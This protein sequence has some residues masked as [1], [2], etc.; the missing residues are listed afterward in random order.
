MSEDVHEPIPRAIRTV[1]EHRSLDEPLAEAAAE[2]LLAGRATAAQIAALLV[3]LRMK[4]E[5]VAEITGF[6]RALRR[7]AV[8]VPLEQDDLVDPVGTGGDGL[9]TF[10]VSTAAAFVAAAAGCRVAKHGNR[11]ISS[12]CGSADV[13]R[14]LGV[15]IDAPPERM[16]RC[17]EQ[18]GIGFFYAQRYHPGMAHVVGPRRELGVRTVFNLLGPLANPA[19]ARR[20]LIGVYD[21]KLTHVI[22]EVLGRLGSARALVVHGEDGL[23]EIS[24][25]GRTT[26]SELHA[27]TI[28]TDWIVPE[29]FGLRRAS[30]EAIRGGQARENAAILRAVLA[31]EDGPRRD[32]VLLNAGA[33]IYVGGRAATIAEGVQLAAQAIDSG[34]ARARLEALAAASWEGG[35]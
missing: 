21:S 32:V 15:N 34:A 2:A 35:A 5:T 26:V 16:A 33:T 17:V 31:G 28:R 8:R 14:E 12:R 20:H 25:S 19:G 9:A 13:L 10:N 22:A 18:L 3:G 4:G 30:L 24:I 27:G 6:V 1:L 29:D 23:D 11:A 7:G